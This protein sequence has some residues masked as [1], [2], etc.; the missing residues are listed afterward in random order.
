MA[1]LS[2]LSDVMFVVRSYK[3]Q[4]YLSMMRNFSESRAMDLNGSISSL[5]VGCPRCHRSY[6]FYK[7]QNVSRAQIVSTSEDLEIP[8]PEHW[9]HKQIL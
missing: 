8:V 5:W 4:T 3:M 1:S 7:L 2:L 9:K 6:L